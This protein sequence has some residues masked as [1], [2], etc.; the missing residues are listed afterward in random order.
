MTAGEG[1]VVVVRGRGRDIKIGFAKSFS[2]HGWFRFPIVSYYIYG[3]I[4]STLP[5]YIILIIRLLDK[6][7]AINCP[8][9]VA[10]VHCALFM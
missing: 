1:F 4:I 3:L 6:F 7:G 9:L 5:L 10:F 8:I 2:V